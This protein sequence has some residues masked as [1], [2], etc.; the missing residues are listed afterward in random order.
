MEGE[1]DGKPEEAQEEQGQQGE[2]ARPQGQQAPKQVERQ[3]YKAL[4][5]KQDARI[6]ELEG[7]VAEAA[8][9]QEAA[10]TLAKEIEKLRAD[11][12][13]ER[14]G[15]ELRLAGARN[16]TAARALLAEHGGDVAELKGAEPWLFAPE[17]PAGGTTG[18]EPAGTV[19]KTEQQTMDRRRSITGLDDEE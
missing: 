17:P 13:E 11:A 14:T 4:L 5:D 10:D 2:P 12:A 3:D 7:Q 18:L 9:S 8:K 1:Q 16:V 19:A 15:Y 6:R